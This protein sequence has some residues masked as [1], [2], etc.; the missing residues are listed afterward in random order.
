MATKYRE[1]HMESPIDYHE[2]FEQKRGQLL[3]AIEALGT[4]PIQDGLFARQDGVLTVPVAPMNGDGEVDLWLIVGD[5]NEVYQVVPGED[6]DL[7]GARLLAGGDTL[8]DCN[9]M[10]R[11]VSAVQAHAPN[12]SSISFG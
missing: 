6:G 4:E 10:G 3:R 5:G 2:V 1:Q 7:L 12:S 8:E 11:I 9:A